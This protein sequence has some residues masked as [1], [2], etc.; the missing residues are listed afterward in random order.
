MSDKWR[1][2][3]CCGRPTVALLVLDVPD[4]HLFFAQTLYEPPTKRTATALAQAS[5]AD[6]AKLGAFE[7]TSPGDDGKM[8]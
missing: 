4:D 2:W 5:K 1:R 6:L 3:S 7:N 8:E